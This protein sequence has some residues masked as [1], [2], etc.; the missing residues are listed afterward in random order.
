MSDT[1]NNG[2]MKL[3]NP[4]R[5]IFAYYEDV[6][7]QVIIVRSFGDGERVV[8]SPESGA[9]IKTAMFADEMVEDSEGFEDDPSAFI[10]YL[11]PN[12]YGKLLTQAEQDA[13]SAAMW[14]LRVKFYGSEASALKPRGGRVVNGRL[15]RR[16][17]W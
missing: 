10:Y 6:E 7:E 15:G 17:T 13:M 8:I 2:M 4:P 14:N 16:R 5:N 1:G 12:E 9:A 3:E 11:H